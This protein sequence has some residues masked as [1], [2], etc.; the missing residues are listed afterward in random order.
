MQR[1]RGHRRAAG[2]VTDETGA[3]TGLRREEEADHG[4]GGSRRKPC[5]A[6]LGFPAVLPGETG[7]SPVHGPPLIWKLNICPM[8]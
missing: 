6:G 2:R 3:V 5:K 8:N 4:V 7:P 1:C